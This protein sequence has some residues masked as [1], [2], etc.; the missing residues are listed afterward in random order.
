[1]HAS[2]NEWLLGGE[3]CMLVTFCCV[4]GGVGV[5]AQMDLIFFSPCMTIILFSPCMT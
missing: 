1:M 3:G 2:G 4:L 5:S